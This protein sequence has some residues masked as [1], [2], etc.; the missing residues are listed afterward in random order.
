M[1][2]SFLLLR[3]LNMLP[4]QNCVNIRARAELARLKRHVELCMCECVDLN[5]LHDV[6]PRQKTV[7]LDVPFKI[8]NELCK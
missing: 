4:K 7:C 2:L 8:G 6:P 5:T 3:K 1:I